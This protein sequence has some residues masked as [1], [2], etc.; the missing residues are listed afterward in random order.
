MTYMATPNIRTQ[1]LGVKKF[2]ILVD[3]S[4]DIIYILSV[5]DLCLGVEKKIF[6][7][8]MHFHHMTYMATP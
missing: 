4:L 6:K 1:A 2:I 8:I 7:K 5:F 3:P